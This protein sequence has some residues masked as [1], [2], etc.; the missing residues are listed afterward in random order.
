MPTGITVSTETDRGEI[1]GTRHLGFV[2]IVE[3]DRPDKSIFLKA[4]VPS[5]TGEAAN[6]VQTAWNDRARK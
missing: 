6:T 5:W 3:L 1:Y 2:R 4:D